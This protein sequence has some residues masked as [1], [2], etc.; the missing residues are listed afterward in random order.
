MPPHNLAKMVIFC[1]LFTY[2]AVMKNGCLWNRFRYV[3]YLALPGV[4]LH[5]PCDALK[6]YL[7]LLN[8]EM[9][10]KN[11]FSFVFRSLIRIIDVRLRYFR[12]DM[13]AKTFVFTLHFAHLF[14]SLQI[15]SMMVNIIIYNKV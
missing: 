1:H 8:T 11:E 7:S 6:V 3:L 4:V 13:N 10:K 15:V 5:F 12:L 9:I 14:V 2:K